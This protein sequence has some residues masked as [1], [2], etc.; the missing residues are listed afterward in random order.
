M[1]HV[2]HLFQFFLSKYR[3]MAQFEKFWVYCFMLNKILKT[4][5]FSYKKIPKSDRNIASKC[6][7]LYL[8]LW[9][10]HK[11]SREF[12]MVPPIIKAKEEYINELKINEHT[13]SFKNNL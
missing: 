3:E 9:P 1:F 10:R 12:L 8:T 11:M 6:V 4:L 7:I 5:S 2:N 13:L